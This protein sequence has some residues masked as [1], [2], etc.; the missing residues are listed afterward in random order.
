MKTRPALALGAAALLTAVSSGVQADGDARQGRYEAQT[1]LGCHG[2]DGY[3]NVYPSY[4]VPKVGGQNPDY[5]VSALKAYKQGKRKHATMQA[6]A[7]SLTEQQMK[8][9]AAY[10]ASIER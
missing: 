4:H 8:D 3:T 5:I 9:I 7:R 6:Q 1:C 10:F 2:V